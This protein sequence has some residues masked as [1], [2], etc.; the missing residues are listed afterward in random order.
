M[1]KSI[2][3]F[4]EILVCG[5]EFFKKGDN[6]TLVCV[7]P[8]GLYSQVFYIIT[9]GWAVLYHF[10][11]SRFARVFRFFWIFFHQVEK[12]NKNSSSFVFLVP[13]NSKIVCFLTI[14][15]FGIF[16]IFSQNRKTPL[17]LMIFFI[18]FH[19][20]FKKNCGRSTIL[21]CVYF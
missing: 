10:I 4:G 21:K 6:R 20:F 2:V 1:L 9:R 17:K 13:K 3:S 5:R 18:N 7:T 16:V 15:F 19:V 11:K 14:F 12:I 8:G